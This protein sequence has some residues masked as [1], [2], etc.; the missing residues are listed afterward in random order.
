MKDTKETR[1]D[2]DETPKRRR[3]YVEFG[4]EYYE[5]WPACCE[6]LGQTQKGKI[7][8]KKKK[9]E[10]KER[11]RSSSRSRSQ[12]WNFTK[13]LLRKKLSAMLSMWL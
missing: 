2:K 8:K 4:V 10:K 6:I 13:P 7:K 12:S 5:Y 1:W 3:S 9:K 11:R